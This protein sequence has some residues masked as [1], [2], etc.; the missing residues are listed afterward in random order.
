[1]LPWLFP[2]GV[3]VAVAAVSLSD[4]FGY[5]LAMVWGWVF[6]PY[7]AAYIRSHSRTRGGSDNVSPFRDDDTQY[8]RTRIP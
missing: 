6:F 1:M 8:W 5:F 4:V 2:V 7:V 3:V